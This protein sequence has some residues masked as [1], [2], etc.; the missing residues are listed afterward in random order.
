[1]RQS[2]LFGK[3]RKD[4]NREEQSVNAE[5]LIR[6][7]F[8]EKQLAGVYN[9][10]P[11]GLK[12]F[13]KIENVI[14][15]E[16]NAIGAQEMLMSSLQNKDLWQ[17][18]GRW[19]KLE[20]IMYQFKDHHGSTVGLAATH[21]ETITNIVKKHVNSYR[22]LPVYLYQIQTKFR[23]EKRAKSGILRGREFS[24][25]DLYS[26]HTDQEDLDRYYMIVHDA[27][28]KIFKRL[29][30]E[31]FS[32]EASGGDMSTEH[33]H[34]FM[35][36][37]DAG[38]DITL[39]CPKCHWAQ[40]LEIAAEIKK[41]PQCS[42]AL[43]KVKTVEAGNIFRQGDQYSAPLD[44]TYV[45]KEGHKQNVILGSYGIG[46]G[47]LLGTIVEAN[48]DQDGIIWTKASTPYHLHLLNLVRN[49]KTGEEV[50][51][52]LTKAGWEVLYDDRDI[53]F[54]KKLKDADLIGICFQLLVSDK[55]KELELINRADHKKML[56]GYDQVIKELEK[57]YSPSMK[58]IEPSAPR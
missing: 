10:L 54:G 56:I 2:Q 8:I 35:V 37:T 14:R 28:L 38:E 40:N 53:S 9:F 11:L 17:K 19:E 46:L 43:A 36:A 20:P 32:V 22:D 57:F 45:D 18:S 5:L 49:V 58:A 50:Y 41:C 4:I 44:L 52:K 23:D 39:L 26:F 33:S 1:M 30:L 6:A 51:R 3:T 55:Q 29:G 42:T 13:R 24:M 31:A 16:M 25:K 27:Y 21:E 48:H 47:R 15:E 34:E 12:V 7:G